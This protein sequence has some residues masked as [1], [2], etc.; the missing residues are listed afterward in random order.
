MVDK[1]V[2]NVL[3]V[4]VFFITGVFGLKCLLATEI[5]F[6][7]EM[8]YIAIA[9]RF[10]NGDA[11]LVDDWSPMQL[12]GFLLMPIVGMYYNIFGSMEGIVLFF[13]IIYILMKLVIAVFAIYRLWNY[14]DNKIYTLLGVAFYYFF[15][16]YNI[17]T[18]SYNTIPISMIFLISVIILT[19]KN[20]NIECF[21][22]GIFLAI[23]VLG[24][25]FI[26]L[27]YIAC[28]VMLLIYKI[29]TTSDNK[30]YERVWI[31]VTFGSIS[32]ALIFSLFVFS[33]A[34]FSEIMENLTYIIQ[35]PDHDKGLL[36][37]IWNLVYDIIFDHI[38]I[39]ITNSVCI[40]TLFLKEK[41]VIGRKISIV[42]LILSCIYLLSLRDPFIENLIYIPFMWFALEQIIYYKNE[43]KISLVYII[44]LLSVIGVYLGTNT[45]ILSTSA[46]MSNFATLSCF[47]IGRIEKNQKKLRTIEKVQF[48]VLIAILILTFILRLFI[49]WRSWYK[50]EDFQD[51]I[52]KGPLKGMYAT[53]EVWNDYYTVID[54]LDSVDYEEG[55]VFFCGTYTPL[56]YLYL[57]LEYGTM[58]VA[59]FFLD[60]ERLDLYW[61]MHPEKK[62]DVLYYLELT[63]TDEEK[64]FIE[65]LYDDYDVKL[66]EDR[67]IAIRK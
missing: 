54:D 52:D 64:E 62:P 9:L 32:V 34:S 14:G 55:D 18:L 27:G 6:F 66:M 1:K 41:H 3:W 42:A 24:H 7:D 29:R 50:I 17:D 21:F 5:T 13:R 61:E 46:A 36:E 15:T 12:N 60:Y 11:M 37:K 56:T 28:S 63:Y 57:N 67:M 19:H 44:I 65:K 39:T 16:P 38:F 45:R 2:R 47:I 25:P 48:F 4:V 22:C 51:Y 33:R 8:S 35:E 58:G 30:E 20:N 26:L 10:F 40:V 31:Y 53:E 59:F 23:A 49:V 43:K